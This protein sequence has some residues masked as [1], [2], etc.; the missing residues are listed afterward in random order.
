ME[1][2]SSR[3]F[4]I[5]E[6]RGTL[7]TSVSVVFV[8]SDLPRL[9]PKILRGERCLPTPNPAPKGIP[10][11]PKERERPLG[12]CS[13]PKSSPG[14]RDLQGLAASCLTLLGEG[15]FSSR[16]SLHLISN[17]LGGTGAV[18]RAGGDREGTWVALQPLLSPRPCQSR[19]CPGLGP[20]G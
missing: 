18:C 9:R 10:K 15:K 12:R 11:A 1:A 8:L 3:K 19:I 17:P 7:G 14:C 13:F 2:W 4:E 20:I 6:E 5:T 16:P